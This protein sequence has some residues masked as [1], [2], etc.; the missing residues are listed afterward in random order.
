MAC[1]RR[2]IRNKD[3]RERRRSKPAVRETSKKKSSTKKKEM[4]I[5]KNNNQVAVHK[6]RPLSSKLE[7][8]ISIARGSI[9]AW[10]EREY[11]QESKGGAAT[12]SS[13]KTP[14]KADCVR[15]GGRNGAVTKEKTRKEKLKV[16]T[17]VI[18]KTEK[19]TKR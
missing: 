7:C 15:N 3:T 9:G 13:V 8:K 17:I 12:V 5:G 16:V 14:P 4:I 18:A 1:L 6:K 19:E 2:R 11:R 10:G